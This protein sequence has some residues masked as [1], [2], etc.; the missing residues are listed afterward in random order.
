[1]VAAAA[2]SA[3][4]HTARRRASR[5]WCQPAGIASAARLRS[6]ESNLYGFRTF[7]III[8]VFDTAKHGYTIS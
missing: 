6:Q 2:A 5:D 8:I 4:L 7:R 1:M 3:G